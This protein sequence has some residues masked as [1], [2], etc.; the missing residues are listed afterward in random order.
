MAKPPPKIEVLAAV[1]YT[2][3]T[4]MTDFECCNLKIKNSFRR[5]VRAIVRHLT[6][7]DLTEL[8]YL[9]RTKK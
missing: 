2:A 3:D 9:K 5:I 1:A 4:G 7:E 8:F 6:K